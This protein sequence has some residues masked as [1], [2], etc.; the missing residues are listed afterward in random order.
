MSTFNIHA[1]HNYHVPGASGILSETNANR[2]IKNK[3]ITILRD[4]GHTVYDCTDEDGKT[5][6][7]NLA[8]IVNKC[9][10]HKVDLDI[11]IH[12]N[13]FN[14][15]VQGT[16][17]LQYSDKTKDVATR[18]CKNISALGFTNR[19]VKDGSNLYVLKNTNSKAI[20]IECCFCDNTED[21]KRY[22]PDKMANAIASAILNKTISSK[23]TKKVELEDIYEAINNIND[24]VST[25]MK[26]VKDI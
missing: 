22:N 20:L 25:I 4:E 24:K 26:I 3:L 15:K 23:N 17:V 12:F 18:I 9:N 6:A 11:S 2:V 8:N 10:K 21:A 7:Q 13:A 1:G 5:S 14:G 19:G 16:E